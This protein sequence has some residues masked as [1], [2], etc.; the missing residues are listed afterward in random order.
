[1]QRRAPADVIDYWQIFLRRRWW[2]LIPTVVVTM[3]VFLV[4]GRLPKLYKSETLIL[5]DPQKV[6]TEYV[7]PTISGDVSDRL[8]TISQE[9]LSRTRLQKIIDQFGLYK[10]QKNLAQ[11]DIVEMMR[12]DITLDIV[13]DPRARPGS[14]VGGFKISY[15][16]SS[17][18]LAQQVTRQIASLFIEENLKVREQQAEGTDEF[19]ESELE[20]SRQ[21]LE[22]HE[23]KVKEF[24]NHYMGS[25]PEQQQTSLQMLGQFQAM[26]Q[27]NGDAIGR[28]EQQK[29]YL[30]SLL[31]TF[32]NKQ[33]VP[34]SSFP[35]LEQRRNELLV[36]EQKYLPTH[37]DVIRL[38]AQV[39]ALETQAKAQAASENANP[40]GEPQQ[41]QFQINSITQ[42]LKERNRR[43]KELEEK[44]RSLQAKVENLPAVEAQAAELNRDYTIS[45]TNYESLLQKKNASA[46]ATEMEHRAKGEQF[47]ILD[48]ASFPQKPSKPNLPMVNGMGVMAGLGLGIGLGL[49]QEFRDRSMH[50]EKDLIHY[51]PSTL[52]GCMPVIVTAESL[53][54][55]KRAARR[56][57]LMSSGAGA[58]ILIVVV[59]LYMRGVLKFDLTGWF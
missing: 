10:D 29:T 44:V 39:K 21:Q 2:I 3:S 26:L 18:A 57:W 20:K 7:R 12:K 30:E 56:T 34:K 47:R 19:I 32:A 22:A 52:L 43:Q 4:S 13:A 1:M 41:L 27:T 49:L 40:T 48:P 54:E 38:R 42:D 45:K 23:K 58:A 31:Q 8:Q 9:I 5:V 11:E 53:R 28:D 25:L 15:F 33:G 51:V 35:E 46:M 59:A 6:P 36:A 50:G 37:P 24:K 55:A 16:G 14:G 17:P